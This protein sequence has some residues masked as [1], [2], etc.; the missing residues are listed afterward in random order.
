MASACP[1]AYVALAQRLADAAG[2]VV[3]GYFRSGFDVEHKQDAS[4][5]TVAD[6][7]AE[8]AMRRIIAQEAPEHG[9]VGE[10]H[11][12]D[13]PEAEWVWQLDPI[14]G[15]NSFVTGSP[16]F[17]ILIALVHRGE[18]VLGLMDQPI[19]HERWL[20]H[21]AEATTLNGRPCRARACTDLAQ[22]VHYTSGPEYYAGGRE[23]ALQRMVAATRLTRYSADCYAVGL[24]VGGHVDL[25]VECGV[26]THD[27]AALVPIVENAGGA[28]S[29]WRGERHDMVSDGD[30]VATG[31][32]RLH[33][34]VLEILRG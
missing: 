10:E 22:A 5:V 3:R 34:Q 14:D 1:E 23:A 11:G 13:R 33:E 18:A 7:E 2:S 20:A 21:G 6:R 9:V 24:L 26:Q 12:A 29:N 27:Y 30:F 15:T 32:P 17:G 8:A 31:D 25:V 19:L 16:L 28:C 4:L